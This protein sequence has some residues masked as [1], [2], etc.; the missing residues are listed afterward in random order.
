[1]DLLDAAL[2]FVLT[3]AALATVVT[4]TME[5]CHR[6]FA[7]R[8]ANLIEVLK[9]L[10]A[11]LKDGPLKMEPEERWNFIVSTL[12]NPTYPAKV[13]LSTE[14][15]KKAHGTVLP[16][17]CKRLT[18]IGFLRRVFAVF[19]A[20]NSRLPN[21]SLPRSDRWDDQIEA[22]SGLDADPSIYDKISLEHVL[23]KLI[24]TD[25]VQKHAAQAGDDLKKELE[26]LARKFEEYNSA[27]GA[28]FK[29]R[30]QTYSTIIAVLFAIVANVDGL[31]IFEAYLNDK[32]LRETVIAQQESFETT[33]ENA[34]ER[35]EALAAKVTALKEAQKDLAEHSAGGSTDAAAQER[36]EEA[37]TQAEKD[38]AEAAGL[39]QISTNA[40]KIRNEFAAL[41]DLGIPM[42]AAF[43]PFCGRSFLGFLSDEGQSPASAE[44]SGCGDTAPATESQD[45]FF[46]WL[47]V[48]GTGMLIGLGAPFWFDVA[49]RIAAVR[50]MLGGKAS[51]EERLSG[52][53]ANGSAET[54]EEIVKMVMADLPAAA[55][56]STVQPGPTG[57]P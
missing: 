47:R 54:R 45:L 23:R 13:L 42:G 49:K 8:K 50:T 19:G 5:V 28:A 34:L 52:K 4:I 10:N 18:A 6:L 44:K 27:I 12:N 56:A 30:A 53:D 31:R 35:Q 9:L 17:K 33:F 43:Y 22:L 29:R 57:G 40:E 25:A 15:I 26:K 11:E 7:V 46:W 32:N 1:M 37:V 2:A 41:V 3:L 14:E 24:E 20:F 55:P 51:Q 48:I 21:P 38:L 16:L 39:K 36:Y